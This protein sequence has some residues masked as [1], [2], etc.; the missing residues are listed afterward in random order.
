MPSAE[1]LLSVVTLRC[2]VTSSPLLTSQSQYRIFITWD[3]DQCTVGY[4]DHCIESHLLG[5]AHTLNS[6]WSSFRLDHLRCPFG[7]QGLAF[8]HRGLPYC[9]QGHLYGHQGLPFSHQC[10]PF[11]HQGL[12]LSYI[13]VLQTENGYR[14]TKYTLFYY[15]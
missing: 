10:L 3:R 13:K 11:G 8:G 9:H 7:H 4:N 6:F 2:V 14:L 5:F 12:P 15:N 1:C